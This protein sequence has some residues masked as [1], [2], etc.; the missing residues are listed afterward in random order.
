MLVL[1]LPRRATA[2]SAAPSLMLMLMLTRRL[3]TAA[4]AATTDAA[5]AA[6]S[7]ARLTAAAVAR[8]L[9]EASALNGCNL[10]GHSPPLGPPSLRSDA[11]ATA[12]FAALRFGARL[13]ASVVERV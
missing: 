13:A 6:V 1:M 8:R 2:A 11:G 10:H 12:T 3:A 5:A 7:A 9:R 4:A